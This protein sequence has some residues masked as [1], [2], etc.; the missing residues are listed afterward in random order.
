MTTLKGSATNKMP[1]EEGMV[2][3]QKRVKPILVQLNRLEHEG[4]FRAYALTSENTAKLREALI[5]A[6]D[7]AID[8]IE[9]EMQKVHNGVPEETASEP[10]F[11][12]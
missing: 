9:A 10:S 12:F 7:I 5:E 11:K 6:V 1:A 4:I 2:K 3:V 8:A